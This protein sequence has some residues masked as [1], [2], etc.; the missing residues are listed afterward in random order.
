LSR[1]ILIAAALVLAAG[2]AHAQAWPAK[3]VRMIVPYP[4]GGIGDT[5]TRAVS[6]RLSAALG[7]PF[8]I[9][10]LAGGNQIIG[11]QALARAPAD[12][13]TLFLVSPT[14]VVLHPIL[15]R[16]LPYDPDKFTMVTQLFNSPMFLLVDPKLPANSVAELVALAKQK[17]GALT[18]GSNGEGSA[19]HLATEMFIQMTGIQMT[20]IPYKGT[21]QT[22][23]DLMNGNLNMTFFPGAGSLPLVKDGRLKALAVTTAQRSAALPDVPTVAQAGVKGY[24][25]DLWWG[26]AAPEGTP[27]AVAER[28]ASAVAKV[29]ADPTLKQQFAAQAVEFEAST[30]AGFTEF[31]RNERK[32]WGELVRRLNLPPQE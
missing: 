32:R 12:G 17:P 11:A 20:H 15:R 30:P 8:V 1:K 31:V 28:I 21:A 10:N 25:A 24:V 2:A 22:N 7:Q 14:S 26:L 27:P 4:P 9:E 18:F 3:S 6:A 5:A 16:S 19:V 29:V 23:V 13:Y